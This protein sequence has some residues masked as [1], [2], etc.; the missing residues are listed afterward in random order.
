M[1]RIC[2]S[3]AHTHTSYAEHVVD[4]SQEICTSARCNTHIIHLVE[5]TYFMAVT[6]GVFC[7]DKG[8]SQNFC[9]LGGVIFF[10][11]F[12]LLFILLFPFFLPCPLF[13]FLFPFPPIRS[14][15]PQIQLAARGSG[16]A[17]TSPVGSGLSPSR[18]RVCCILAL[19]YDIVSVF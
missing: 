8:R 18:N 2:V 5:T 3:H 11:F 4:R 13:S 6:D 16:S 12:T 15:T 14:N 1:P 10:S 9:S 17:E 19:K 7:L